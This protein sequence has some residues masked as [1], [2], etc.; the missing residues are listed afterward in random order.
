MVRDG[1]LKSALIFLGIRAAFCFNQTMPKLRLQA[2]AQGEVQR[3]LGKLP[4]DVRGA[5]KECAVHFEEMAALDEPDLD[6]DTLGL[7]EGNNRLDPPPSEPAEM[8]RIRLFMDNLWDFAEGD[9]EFF[10][11]EVRITFLHELGHYLGWDEA[12]IEEMG[13]A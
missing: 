3:A 11:D 13:L 4:P 12:K 9:D 8:P 6:E 2:L 5:A 7:F 10:R 1:F